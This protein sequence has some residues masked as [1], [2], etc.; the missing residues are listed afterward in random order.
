[1]LPHSLDPNKKL[2]KAASACENTM[3]NI[4]NKTIINPRFQ[5]FEKME[6]L[7]ISASLYVRRAPSQVFYQIAI[8]TVDLYH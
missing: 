5:I 6:L 4:K 2:V 8:I 7:H 1:M 3:N